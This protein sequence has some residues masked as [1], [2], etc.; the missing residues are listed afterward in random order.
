[1]ICEAEGEAVVEVVVGSGENKKVYRVPGDKMVE[2]M[3]MNLTR[4]SEAMRQGWIKEYQDSVEAHMMGVGAD[5]YAGLHA[6]I[7]EDVKRG[8]G[9]GGTE[10]TGTRKTAREC[11]ARAQTQ[12]WDGVIH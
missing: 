5:P 7:R 8:G 11:A 1:M 6:V 3:V 4:K 12:L 10:P 2:M 9:P